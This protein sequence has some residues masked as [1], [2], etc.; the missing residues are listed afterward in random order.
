MAAYPVLPSGHNPKAS[1]V[2][3]S[4]AEKQSCNSTTSTSLGFSPADSKHF[5][6]ANRDM[7]YPTCGKMVDSLLPKH[8]TKVLQ[9]WMWWIKKKTCHLNTAVL[10]KCRGKVC[11]HLLGQNLHSLFLKMVFPD[12]GL[13]SQ[14]CCSS[15]IWCRT[16]GRRR[17]GQM[18]IFASVWTGNA[19]LVLCS[20]LPTLQESKIVKHLPGFHHLL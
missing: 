14:N 20:F 18:D 11:H 15:T 16:D 17:P 6:A 13:A 4:L 8:Y 5:S 9:V 19:D 12:K 2:M 7:S 10:F 1:Y 3:S